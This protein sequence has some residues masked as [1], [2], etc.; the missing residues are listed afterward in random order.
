MIQISII[1]NNF[2]YGSYLRNHRTEF[3]RDW[4]LKLGYTVDIEKLGRI[5]DWHNVLM[6][7]SLSLI[8]DNNHRS[9]WAS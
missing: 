4:A 1:V 2:N 6:R 3:A 8:A 7:H 5:R 9:D